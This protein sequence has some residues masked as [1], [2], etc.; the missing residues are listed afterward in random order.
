MPS[1]TPKQR[2]NA[3]RRRRED[4]PPT[5]DDANETPQ[6]KGEDH[7]QLFAEHFLSATEKVEIDD[8][9]ADDNEGIEVFHF[10]SPIVPE[11]LGEG[12]DLHD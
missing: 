2:T 6:S 3:Q 11:L 1:A 5:A 8:Q 10:L 9:R 4:V 7:Q 12:V